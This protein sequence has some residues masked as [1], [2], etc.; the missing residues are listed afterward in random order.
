[1]L[2]LITTL[3]QIDG[4][5]AHLFSLE[6]RY[7]GTWVREIFD[8]LHQPPK[9]ELDDL[10]QDSFEQENLA[11]DLSLAGV[12]EELMVILHSWMKETN[13]PFGDMA[14]VLAEIDNPTVP[15]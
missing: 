13:D 2:L 15:Q 1:M 14:S 6:G 11:D 8:R 3:L 10:Q 4:D 9:I 7:D 12:K 5:K